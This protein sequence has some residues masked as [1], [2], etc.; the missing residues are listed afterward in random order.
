[1]TMPLAAESFSETLKKIFIPNQFSLDLI[2]EAASRA[3]A[4][5]I[6]NLGTE[7][8]YH[9]RIYYPPED[10]VF[11][12]CLTGLAGVGKSETISALRRILPGPVKLVTSHCQSG[13]ILN[14]HW[15][16]SARGKASGRQQ[17]A[18]FLGGEITGRVNTAKL[19]VECRRRVNRD[20]VSLVLLEELQHTNTGQGA[21]KVTDLLLTMS[22]IGI[23][24]IYVANYSLVH[25]LMKR[26]SEDKQRLLS[27]PRVMLPDA[28]NSTDWYDYIQA[29]LTVSNQRLCADFEELATEV[30]RWTFGVKRLVTLLLKQAYIEAR[31]AGSDIVRMNDISRAY[32]S[33]PFTTNRIDVEDLQRLAIQRHGGSGRPDLICPFEVP[34]NSNVVEFAIRERDNRI[35]EKIYESSRTSVERAAEKDAK[36]LL[37]YK[38]PANSNR[39][40][41][42]PIKNLTTEEREIRY[43]K[44]VTDFV[45]VKKTTKPIL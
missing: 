22:G 24:M 25:K 30:Y 42:P 21:S 14:S 1:M 5:S 39:A 2:L 19:L 11:P 27:E 18:D 43:H 17:L 13:H 34:M 8:Q 20:G 7:K 15:Y 38:K 41:K 26:N 32:R 12:T 4:H 28:P 6:Q 35:N 23:P 45:S 10:E 37:G 3:R 9:A 40:H 31:Q 29:C 33:V 44:M 16:A 36:A